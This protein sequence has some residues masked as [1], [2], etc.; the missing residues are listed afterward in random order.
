MLFTETKLNDFLQKL[1]VYE[2]NQFLKF[3]DSPFFNKN[4][5]ITNMVAQL[6]VAYKKGH[7]ADITK[8]EVWRFLKEKKPYNDLKFRRYCS[9]TVS[10]LET[11]LAN[12]HFQKHSNL[13]RAFTLAEFNERGLDSHFSKNIAYLEAQTQK[14]KVIDSFDYLDRLFFISSK[15]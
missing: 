3:L 4:E 15:S 6:S 11:F 12:L 8:L 14:R 9:D 2:W 7:T 1:N 10:L 5:A 13:V